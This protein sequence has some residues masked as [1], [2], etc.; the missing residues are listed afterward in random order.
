MRWPG[1]VEW[2]SGGGGGGGRGEGGRRVVEQSLTPAEG[3]GAGPIGALLHE[4]LV[5][6]A[7]GP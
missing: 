5:E 3:H 7:P 2:C 6:L 4:R 1:E